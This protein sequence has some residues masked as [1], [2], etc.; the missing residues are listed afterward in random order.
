MST[1]LKAYLSKLERL[2]FYLSVTILLL[3]G[4]SS[5]HIVS[6][7]TL[8]ETEEEVSVIKRAMP[9]YPNY[10]VKNG[11]E[12]SV[13]VSFS[14]EKDGNVSDIQVEASDKDGL[15]DASVILAVQ[16]WVFTKPAKKV[17][18]NYVALE[19]ALTDEPD[20]TFFS[21]VEIIQIQGK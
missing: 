12:G 3:V 11:I 7:S 19:F 1:K 20:T 13:L 15:F 4:T 5:F 18:N 14:I 21:N 2:G 9:I 6:A 10:A 17:R 16:R 8:G